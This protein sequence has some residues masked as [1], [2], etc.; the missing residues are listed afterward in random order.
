[1]AIVLGMTVVYGTWRSSK[2]DGHVFTKA[3]NIAY[4]S[5]ARIAWGIAVSNVIYLCHNGYGGTIL[6]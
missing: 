2:K 5:L 6:N 3:E 4:G 1:M